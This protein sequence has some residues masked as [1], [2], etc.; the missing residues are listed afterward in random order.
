MAQPDAQPQSDGAMV[1]A[2]A[3]ATPIQRKNRQQKSQPLRPK[4]KQQQKWLPPLPQ[5]LPK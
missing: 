4:Q 5:L 1:P 2:T 3:D